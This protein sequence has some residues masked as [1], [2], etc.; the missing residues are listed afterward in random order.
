M[1][2]Q[3]GSSVGGQRSVD[4]GGSRYYTYNNFSRRSM[5]LILQ[6]KR[7]REQLENGNQEV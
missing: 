5:V 6:V 2:A 3:Y 4:R 7:N 1:E